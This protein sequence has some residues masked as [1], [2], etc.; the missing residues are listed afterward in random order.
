MIDINPPALPVACLTKAYQRVAASYIAES[1]VID[2]RV[3][4]SDTHIARMELYSILMGGITSE[5][6]TVSQRAIAFVDCQ[7]DSELS[8]KMRE[9]VEKKE[10]WLVYLTRCYEIKR[11][12]EL[13]AHTRAEFVSN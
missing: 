6:E 1:R 12:R 3:Y 9:F 4:M 10:K 8:N 2:H 5:D 13:R 7:S 11:R